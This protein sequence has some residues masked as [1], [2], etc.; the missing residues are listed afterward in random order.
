MKKFN[1]GAK[2]AA[3]AFAVLLFACSDSSSNSNVYS[4]D[5]YAENQH[6][7]YESTEADFMQCRWFARIL[8]KNGIHIR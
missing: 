7:C 2:A 6:M 5:E 1:L 4:C 3:V 8:S